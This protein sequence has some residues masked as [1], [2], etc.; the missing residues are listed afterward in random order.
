MLIVVRLLLSLVGVG[1][2]APNLV[3][4]LRVSLIVEQP[5]SKTLFGI[6]K[7]SSEILEF[8]PRFEKGLQGWVKLGR[9]A[10]QHVVNEFPVGAL[11]CVSIFLQAPLVLVVVRTELVVIEL[12]SLALRSCGVF[13]VWTSIGSS[14]SGFPKVSSRESLAFHLGKGAEPFHCV[15]SEETG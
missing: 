4:L 1:V 6:D 15:S 8:I 5:W 12:S 7:V 9:G 11:L 10:S 3:S 2:V 13:E 14:K